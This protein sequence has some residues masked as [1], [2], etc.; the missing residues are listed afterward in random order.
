MMRVRTMWEN[1][2]K[3]PSKT[4][5]TFFPK[6]NNNTFNFSSTGISYSLDGG[7]TWTSLS[8]GDTVT[9][10]DSNIQG[11]MWKGTMTPQT[12]AGIGKFSSTGTFWAFGNPMSLLFGDNFKN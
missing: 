8:S 3:D 10:T 2:S 12:N 6:N 7:K 4:Y 5:L 9:V 11:I 1:K